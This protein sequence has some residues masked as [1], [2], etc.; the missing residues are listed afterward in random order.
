MALIKCNECGKEVS[1]FAKTCPVCGAPINVDTTVK[2]KIFPLESSFIQA[3]VNVRITN[4]KGR[5]LWSGRSGGVA[6]FKI[7]APTKI[8]ITAEKGFHNPAVGVIEPGKKYQHIP[9]DY[10]ISWKRNYKI[11]EVD[12][13]DAD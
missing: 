8:T 12:I 10:K 7:D 13:I 3:L 6:S 5:L 9:N 11:V 4:D 2:I 1:E